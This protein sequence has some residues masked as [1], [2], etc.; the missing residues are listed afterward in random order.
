MKMSKMK[1]LLSF[2]LLIALFNACKPEDENPSGAYSNGVFIVNE[3]PFSGGSGSVD[4]YDRQKTVTNDIYAKANNGAKIGSILQ[5][6]TIYGGKAYLMVNNANKVIITDPN[7]FLNTGEVTSF[8]Y[9][10][11]MQPIDKTRGYVSEWGKDGV[12]GAIKVFDFEL[13]TVAKTIPLKRLGAGSMLSTGQALWVVNNSGLSFPK[14]DSTVTVV[15]IAADSI[16]RYIKVDESPN[17]IV[18][19]ANGEIWV[20]C[21]KSLNKIKNNA[22]EFSI[23]VP[24]YSSRLTTDI[25]KTNL[26]FVNGNK[27]YQKD[28]LN[29]GKNTPSV[30]LSQPYL[31]S[32]YAIGFDPKSGLMYCGDAKNYNSAGKVYIF[33]PSSKAL[34]DS[35]TVGIAP[36]GFVFQ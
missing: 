1:F 13:K 6:M 14:Q 16:V 15:D 23:K 17:S 26:Y 27:I 31:V 21:S 10:N 12:N 3:G 19:D 4:F 2:L 33:D 20:L 7:T 25:T 29:F 11:Y 9:P 8:A 35:L 32:P 28:L 18:Q 24:D 22:V 36:N 34:K 5:S 30:F